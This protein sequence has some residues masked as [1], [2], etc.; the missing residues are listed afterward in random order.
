MNNFA[1]RQYNLAIYIMF[2]ISFF[3]FVDLTQIRR[4]ETLERRIERLSHAERDSIPIHYPLIRSGI[5]RYCFT[6][7]DPDVLDALRKRVADYVPVTKFEQ[8][9]KENCLMAISLAQSMLIPSFP[10]VSF[11]KGETIDLQLGGIILHVVTEARLS[12]TDAKGVLHIGAIKSKIKKSN[13]SRESAEM[14]A[15]LLAKAMMV[16]HPE[17]IVD[18]HL[19]LCYDVFRQRIASASNLSKNLEEAIRIAEKIASREDLAA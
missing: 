12:W 17:A 5:K 11:E 19:C 18:P 7:F 10:N 6:G 2:Q 15:C 14:A 8:N 4:L 9:E 16:K 13:Y 1:Y 3:T